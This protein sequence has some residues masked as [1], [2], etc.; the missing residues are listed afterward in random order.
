[1]GNGHAPGMTIGRCRDEAVAAG[2]RFAAGFPAFFACLPTRFFALA[3]RS[4]SLLPA[5]APLLR[6]AP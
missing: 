4:S 6:D 5:T 3:I 1:M 2:L